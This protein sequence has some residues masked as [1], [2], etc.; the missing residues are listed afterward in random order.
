M[1]FWRSFPI[2]SLGLDDGTLTIVCR[3]T[4]W[5]RIKVTLR[6]IEPGDLATMR[7]LLQAA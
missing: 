6:K 1:K 3:F 4:P 2:K 7:D 5:S